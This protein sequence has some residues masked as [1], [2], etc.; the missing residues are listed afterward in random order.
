METSTGSYCH[1]RDQHR[2]AA[3]PYLPDRQAA[4]TGLAQQ[5]YAPLVRDG[6]DRA[7]PINRE[8][9]IASHIDSTYGYGG[10]AAA[11]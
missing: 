5:A 1:R 4:V 9:H 2:T 10:D 11:A 3:S 7:A 8:V 6:R